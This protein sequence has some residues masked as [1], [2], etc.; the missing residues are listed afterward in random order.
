MPVRLGAADQAAPSGTAPLLAVGVD[1]WRRGWVAVALLDGRFESAFAGPALADVLDQFSAAAVVGVDMPIGLADAGNRSCDVAARKLI[2][3]R[4]PSVFLAP[5]R[6][7]LTATAAPAGLSRQAWGLITKIREVD[8]VTDR[9]VR[10]VH[11]EVSFW[12]MAGRPLTHA[13]KT[14]AGMWDRLAL[15]KAQEIELPHDLGEASV[16]P[17]DDLIDA[18][19]VAWTATR[20]ATG[21]AESVGDRIGRIWF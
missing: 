19:A 3:A 9:R 17:P 13:K 14:W 15:L 6:L 10:E 12:R 18:A 21:V 4:W 2:G 20:I 16:V 8:V 7:A 5:N 11:P 1:G